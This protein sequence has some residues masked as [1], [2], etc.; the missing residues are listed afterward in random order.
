MAKIKLSENEILA[1]DKVLIMLND[2]FCEKLHDL[3]HKNNHKCYDNGTD[4]C[5]TIEKGFKYQVRRSGWEGRNYKFEP[6]DSNA[7]CFIDKI[8]SYEKAL[9]ESLDNL[10]GK[11]R[12]RF[13][14]SITSKRHNDELKEKKLRLRVLIIP[15]ISNKN[16]NALFNMQDKI[17]VILFHR[18]D[19]KNIDEEAVKE[20]FSNRY[21]SLIS[22]EDVKNHKTREHELIKSK[23]Y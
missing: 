4:D 18:L 15:V 5:P 8:D 20:A 17:D 1:K 14:T 23:N 12:D 6:G 19:V 16:L 21:M 2:D 11:D 9:I 13:D 22:I 7:D 3:Y 10:W